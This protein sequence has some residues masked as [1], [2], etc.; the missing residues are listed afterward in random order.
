MRANHPFT[1]KSK[2]NRQSGVLSDNKLLNSI[3]PTKV[4]GEQLAMKSG[5]YLM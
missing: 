1:V 2:I 3:S 5:L 4:F